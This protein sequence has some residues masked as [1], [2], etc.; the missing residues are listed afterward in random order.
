MK[1][2]SIN[3]Y[4]VISMVIALIGFWS[5]NLPE[6]TDPKLISWMLGV[7][8]ALSLV[9][10]TF[11]ASGE[12][13]AKSWSAVFWAVNVGAFAATLLSLWGSMGLVPM[14]LVTGVIGTINIL[15]SSMG[16]KKQ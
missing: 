6:T 5:G 11:F 4:V 10:K 12:W 7:S 3:A 15:V 9:L 14:S 13:S 1:T 16:T 2:V 8:A